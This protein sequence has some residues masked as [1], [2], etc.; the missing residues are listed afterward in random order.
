MS[1][2]GSLSDVDGVGHFFSSLPPFTKLMILT[3]F[4]SAALFA[5]GGL[6]VV[7]MALLWP[8]I[9]GKLQVSSSA[10]KQV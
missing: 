2:V 5:F 8:L 7:D 10:L 3:W 6:P 4:T 9:T 1:G